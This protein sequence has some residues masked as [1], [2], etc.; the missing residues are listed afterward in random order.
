MTILFALSGFQSWKPFLYKVVLQQ[1]NLRK[2]VFIKMY[3]LQINTL[4]VS[5]RVPVHPD[6]HL[7]WNDPARLVQE[8][9]THGDCKHSLMSEIMNNDNGVDTCRKEDNR[10]RIVQITQHTNI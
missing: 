7:H 1:M 6:S 4:P 10:V 5:Q 3:V 8:P 2:H 9:W